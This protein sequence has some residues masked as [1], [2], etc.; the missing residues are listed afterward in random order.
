[1]ER[2]RSY[3]PALRLVFGGLR[4]TVPVTFA[5]IDIVS[6][7]PFDRTQC[8]IKRPHLIPGPR[9]ELLADQQYVCDSTRPRHH[10]RCL[11]EEVRLLGVVGTAHKDADGGDVLHPLT[12]AM[13]RLAFGRRWDLWGQRTTRAQIWSIG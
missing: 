1:M 12:P 3:L 8:E 4:E 13:V 5:S 7:A 6:S 11:T 10:D 9:D 2:I